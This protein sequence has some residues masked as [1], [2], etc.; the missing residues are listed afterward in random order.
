[1]LDR[2]KFFAGMAG[3]AAIPLMGGIDSKRDSENL[4]LEDICKAHAKLLSD[5]V[6]IYD[7]KWYHLYASPLVVKSL[8]PLRLQSFK[9]VMWARGG[10]GGTIEGFKVIAV[11]HLAVNSVYFLGAEHNGYFY[12]IKADAF[13][14]RHDSYRPAWRDPRW[15]EYYKLIADGRV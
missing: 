11:P 7:D 13:G 8:K 12:D 1:M 4:K 15:A 2:R 5:N 10:Y 9:A 3:C 6:R 14:K